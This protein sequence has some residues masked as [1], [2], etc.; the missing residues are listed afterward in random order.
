MGQRVDK[1]EGLGRLSPTSTG[2]RESSG[3]ERRAAESVG[4]VSLLYE[5]LAEV[6]PRPVQSGSAGT[7]RVP[8]GPR[9]WDP[10]WTPRR[11]QRDSRLT[12]QQRPGMAGICIE[13]RDG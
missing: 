10:G 7:V 8:W 1:L 2:T 9:R 3:T 12:F 13:G 4:A 5:E 11:Q 6:H